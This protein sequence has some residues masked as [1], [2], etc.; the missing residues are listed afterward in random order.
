M[1]CML[2]VAPL[3]HAQYSS[4]DGYTAPCAHKGN[5]SIWKIVSFRPGLTSW[6][7]D[8]GSSGYITFSD[9]CV[10]I[11]CYQLAITMEVERYERYSPDRFIIYCNKANEMF[12]YL[13]LRRAMGNDRKLYWVYVGKMDE[14][15]TMSNTVQISCRRT[16]FA[17]APSSG[18]TR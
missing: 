10:Q 4:D 11:E 6:D 12:D 15:E 14:N 17:P 5:I 2:C 3:A 8:E 7:H 13:E 9:A 16:S 1:A 18:S